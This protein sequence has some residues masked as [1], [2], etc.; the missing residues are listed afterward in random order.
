MSPFGGKTTGVASGAVDRCF[1]AYRPP[2]VGSSRA[3]R[4]AG[5][6]MPRL[7]FTFADTLRRALAGG[8]SGFIAGPLALERVGRDEVD[9]QS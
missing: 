1:R 8:A 3:R 4:S 5:G 7:V 9:W 6:S 2:L